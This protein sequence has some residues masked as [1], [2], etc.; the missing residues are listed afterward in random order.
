[1]LTRQMA[2][3]L[4]PYKINVNSVSPGLH[5]HK[6]HNDLRIRRPPAYG[7]KIFRDRNEFNPAP[8]GARGELEDYVGP[9]PVLGVGLR[10]PIL[11]PVSIC[12]WRA[13]AWRRDDINVFIKIWALAA[14]L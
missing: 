13:A 11:L 7:R 10:G 4:A 14:P 8:L 12:P 5:A 6:A 1:M 9:V 3:E 2:V